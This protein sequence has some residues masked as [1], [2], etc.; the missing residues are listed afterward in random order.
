MLRGMSVSRMYASY[1]A[2]KSIN[3]S[4]L[5]AQF[6]HRVSAA[7]LMAAPVGLLGEHKYA[8]S[9]DCEG[10]SGTNPFSGVASMYTKP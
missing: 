10:G 8:T 4:L 5:K 9:T 3:V 7:R 2:S 6:T 1:A